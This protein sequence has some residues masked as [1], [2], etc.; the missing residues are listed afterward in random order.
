LVRAS[1]LPIL[2]CELEIFKAAIL[3]VYHRLNYMIFKILALLF[4]YSKVQ[5][6]HVRAFGSCVQKKEVGDKK[7]QC[8]FV[9][10]N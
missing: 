8:D 4:M 9:S 2:S 1:A 6:L 3:C 10:K 5:K 7:V